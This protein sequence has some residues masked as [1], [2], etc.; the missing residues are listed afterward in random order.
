MTDINDLKSIIM[1]TYLKDYMLE[2]IAKITNIKEYKDGDYIFNEGDEAKNLYAVIDRKVGLE[3]EKNSSTRIFSKHINQGM[4]FGFCSLV[5]IEDKS[6]MD[7]AKALSDTKLFIWKAEDL[8]AL[9]SQDCEMGFLFTKRIAKLLKQG[10][11][12]EIYNFLIY[13]SKGIYIDFPVLAMAEGGTPG[14]R[15]DSISESSHYSIRLFPSRVPA[16]ETC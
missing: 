15:R 10:C 9:F 7:S 4:T 8:E 2:K 1:L 5:D 6:Y 13:T 11:K 16:M 12:S 14:C 3:I